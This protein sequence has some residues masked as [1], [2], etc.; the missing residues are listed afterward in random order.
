MRMEL[1][2][3]PWQRWVHL[4]M[5]PWLSGLLALD[6]LYHA[7]P[8]LR[9][10]LAARIADAH[11]PAETVASYWQRA[12]ALWLN[13]VPPHGPK[14]D[15]LTCSDL[16]RHRRMN[17]LPGRLEPLEDDHGPRARSGGHRD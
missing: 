16:R 9:P 17:P 10:A 8:G 7:A 1:E 15:C 14:H 4:T 6:G 12:E 11:E 13:A 3:G 5:T 2:P